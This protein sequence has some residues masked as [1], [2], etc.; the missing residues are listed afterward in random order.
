M[1]PPVR[2][3]FLFSLAAATLLS[4]L[5]R[6]A[7]ASAAAEPALERSL[8]VPL[9][10]QHRL[11]GTATL[12]YEL[13]APWDARKPVVLVVADGQQYYVRPGATAALQRDV[14]GDRFNV[15]GILTRGSTPDF[16][17]A[18]LDASGHPDWKKAWRLFKA[19]QWVEDIEAVRHALVGNGK[20]ALYG[21]SGGAYLVHQY[22]A[23]HGTHVSRAFTQSPVNPWLARELR[24]PIEHFWEE[25]SAEE[26]GQLR[27]ALAAHPDDRLRMLVTLQ[28]Q[29]F[30]VPAAGLAEARAGL[31]RALATGDEPPYAAARK[32]YQV[33]AVLELSRSTDAV[34]QHVRVLELLYPAGA[35][36]R[37]RV[38][39][40]QPLVD[41]QRELLAPLL[42]LVAEGAIDIP[43]FDLAAA[44]TLAS[45]VFVLAARWDEA[46]DYRTAIALAYSYPNHAL[47]LADDNHVFARLDEARIRGPLVRTFLESGSRS[48]A[49]ERLRKEAE[50][51]SWHEGGAAAVP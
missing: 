9:D 44:H 20:V 46:V 48:P 25:L 41:S 10:H 11:P 33:D 6:A 14:F 7:P 18:A 1:K 47:L 38:D 29:H 26:Q 31:I 27:Q 37:Q 3:I 15:V 30:F 45:D 34:P 2:E 16:V 43:E 35:F 12:R 42:R 5:A 50:P 28:R 4:T 51:W 8:V 17:R 39:V 32:E 40:V 36:T 49:F 23:K 21:R 19:D 22:L 24:L 13:G